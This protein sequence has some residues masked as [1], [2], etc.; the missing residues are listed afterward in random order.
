MSKILCI[1]LS[2][3][4]QKTVLFDSLRLQDVNRSKS[5]IKDAA[6]KAINS[7]RVLNQLEKGCVSA[8]CP[9]GKENQD[10]FLSLIKKDGIKLINVETPGSVRECLTLLDT[11]N[12]TTTEIVVSEPELKEDYTE[13]EEALLGIIRKEIT[14]ADGVLLAGSRPVW[15]TPG[16]CS[17]I[18]KIACDAGK[19]FLADY[20]GQ[21]LKRTLEVCTPAIIKI[22]ENEFVSTFDLSVYPSESE[23]KDLITIKSSELNN[24]IIVTR[25]KKP[26]FAACCGTFTDFPVEKIS[27]V[28]TTA[29]GDSFSAGYLYEFLETGD[30]ETALAKGTWCAARNAENIRCGS[31]EG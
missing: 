28:N 2:A 12:H 6:G 4:I 19:V 16:I 21:D 9:T 11:T 7:A 1:C 31:I 13:T 30:F 5:Y 23:L 25:G 20:C 15:F 14:N 26:T 8:V 10:E 22:N 3:T 24:T 17:I 29:C 18:A 27:P